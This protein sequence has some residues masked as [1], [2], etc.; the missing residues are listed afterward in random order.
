LAVR[1]LGCTELADDAKAVARLHGLYDALDRGN[2]P[3]AILLPFSPSALLNTWRSKN[4]HDIILAAIQK[5]QR[6]NATGEQPPQDTLQMLL[7]E[8]TPVPLIVG[9]S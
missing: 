2:T 9:V 3:A 8:G 1:A 5:R 4:I 7:D 6:A